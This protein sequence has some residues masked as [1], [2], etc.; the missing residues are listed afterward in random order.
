MNPD[1]ETLNPKLWWEC[2]LPCEQERL[3]KKE[4][5]STWNQMFYVGL[6]SAFVTGI[7][8]GSG[9][10]DDLRVP[11]FDHVCLCVCVFPS[12]CLSVWHS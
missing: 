4:A 7:L 10:R 2:T 8:A 5:V 9:I 11:P 1:T 6:L 3:F 12:I